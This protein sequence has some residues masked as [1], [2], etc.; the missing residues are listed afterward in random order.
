MARN[1]TYSMRWSQTETNSFIELMKENVKNGHKTATTFDKMGWDDIKSRF[2]KTIGGPIGKEQLRNKM[3]KLRTEYQ[4]F[5]KLLDTTGFG[6]NK[7]LKTI[8]VDDESVWDK[9][10][11]ENPTWSKFKKHGLY[12]WPD[13]IIIFGDAY[14][15]GKLG[16][17]NDDDIDD[18]QEGNEANI[19][20][21]TNTPS[22]P[23]I[24][25]LNDIEDFQ[26]HTNRSS[27]K[28]RIDRTSTTR[29]KRSMTGDVSNTM[30]LY[31]KYLS[32]KIEKAVSTSVTSL[33]RGGEASSR[34]RD[35]SASACQDILS[36]MT[37]LTKEKYLK[38]VDRICVD[39]VWREIFI[40]AN[41]IQRVWLLDG[42][43]FP[44]SLHV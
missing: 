16:T 25:G 31:E 24:L 10:I 44:C 42:L 12:Y 8:T 43:N 4:Q 28:R 29:R 32:M 21:D 33:I 20:I 17:N 9:A 13:L 30:D 11:Q 22:T 40:T 39:P 3:N 15:Q 18:T 37:D 23:M 19:E 41:D 1:S 14:A 5:K 34:N 2:E 6:W 36:S 38:A 7:V 27:T 35:F 26:E